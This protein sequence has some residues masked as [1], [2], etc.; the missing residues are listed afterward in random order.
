M[1]KNRHIGVARR[2]G[3]HLLLLKKQGEIRPIFSLKPPLP[4]IKG[5]GWEGVSLITPP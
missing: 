3:G 4:L 1:Q 5:E 2:T